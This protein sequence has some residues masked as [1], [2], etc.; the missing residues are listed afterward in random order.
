MF[1]ELKK[2][3]SQVYDLVTQEIDRQKNGLVMIAS[4][5]YASPAVLEAMGTPLSN[6][7][8][9]GYPNKRYYTGN[10]FIDQIED[11]AITRAKELFKAEHVNVQ[12]HSGSTANAAAYFAC[13][14]PGDTV[15]GL[16]LS[17]GGHLTHGSSVNFSGQLYKFVHYG[18]NKET[19]RVDMN[20]VREIALREKPKMIVC[21]ATAY[22]REIDF[23]APGRRLSHCWFNFSRCS[24]VTC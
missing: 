6:K 24:S 13:L 19:E 22:P 5:N 14:K 1:N 4:E 11:L 21:G 20:E 8:S 12:P 2:H 9:E 23:A 16:D 7:Y 17:H 3:D 18:V 15:L 10:Q